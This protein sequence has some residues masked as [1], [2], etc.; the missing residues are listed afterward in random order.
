MP[1]VLIGVPWRAREHRHH[2]WRERIEYGP[3]E[4]WR[5]ST[6]DTHLERRGLPHHP[7]TGRPDPIEVPEHP[8]VP[9]RVQLWR[10]I[11]HPRPRIDPTRQQL[12]PTRRGR[13]LYRAN[14]RAKPAHQ[15]AERYVRRRADL[16]LTAGL[17]RDASAVRQLDFR[18]ACLRRP[19]FSPTR[20]GA[21]AAQNRQRRR[22]GRIER[23]RAS[24]RQLDRYD[25]HLGANVRQRVG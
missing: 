17:E 15:R 6:V 14:R 13:R 25:L 22:T 4:V 21:C 18:Y 5:V 1:R 3:R 8:A 19:M 24:G 16:D 2:E 9:V 20:R 7:S 11:F 23:Q 12:H 10:D